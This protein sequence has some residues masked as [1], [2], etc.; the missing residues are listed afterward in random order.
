MMPVAGEFLKKYLQATSN[1]K[2]SLTPVG[3]NCKQN[4]AAF[5]LSGGVS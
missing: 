2:A 3:V 4:S 1:L 5:V